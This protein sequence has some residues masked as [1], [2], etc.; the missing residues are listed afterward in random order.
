[1]KCTCCNK[2]KNEV[3]FLV[4]FA[5]NS[6][7]CSDCVSELNAIIKKFIKCLQEHDDNYPPEVTFLGSQKICCNYCKL[8][9][10]IFS[11]NLGEIHICLGCLNILADLP[12]QM[13][14]KQHKQLQINIKNL[15]K[16][17]KK[18]LTSQQKFSLIE[19]YRNSIIENILG[20]LKTIK[21]CIFVLTMILFLF[22]FIFN[23]SAMRISNWNVLLQLIE[24]F[25][26]VVM[27]TA[28]NYIYSKFMFLHCLTENL[29]LN[30]DNIR[31]HVKKSLNITIGIF[32]LAFVLSLYYFTAN[33]K[34]LFIG[35]LIICINLGYNIYRYC[36]IFKNPSKMFDYIKNNIYLIS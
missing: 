15:R 27:W 32:A 28:A 6:Y 3:L 24:V 13:G 2:S 16:I 29:H 5:E 34:M 9:T 8:E 22:S 1:M 31:Y 20:K 25:S 33:A 21:R 30:E 17:I 4:Q 12:I 18:R 19:K 23:Y 14:Y 10:D 35:Y 11:I 26:F 7:I 36:K